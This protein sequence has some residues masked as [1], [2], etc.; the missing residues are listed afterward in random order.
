MR[1]I[2]FYRV[3]VIHFV[4]VE[5]F[6]QLLD[7][8][9][10]SAVPSI[11]DDR[12]FYKGLSEALKNASNNSNETIF[13]WKI[14]KEWDKYSKDSHGMSNESLIVTIKTTFSIV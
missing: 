3:K 14:G 12:R 4:K 13:G 7:H 2:Y 11:N 6:Q 1:W 5:N 8:W 10:V 9:I